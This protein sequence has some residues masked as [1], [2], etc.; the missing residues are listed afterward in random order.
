MV[1]IFV[2]PTHW[3]YKL[4]DSTEAGSFLVL[5][6]TYVINFNTCNIVLLYNNSAYMLVYNIRF[7]AIYSVH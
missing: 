1:S 3:P 2:C 4:L 7:P 5:C 6:R